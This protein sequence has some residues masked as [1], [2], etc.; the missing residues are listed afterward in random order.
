VLIPVVL[1]AGATVVGQAISPARGQSLLPTLADITDVSIP[2]GGVAEVYL[3]PGSP[4]LNAFHLVFERGGN[5]ESVG[6]VAVTATRHGAT[7]AQAIRL[8]TLST[9]HFVGYTTLS[10]GTWRFNVL[11]RIGGRTDSFSVS[12]VLG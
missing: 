8:A 2:G 1:F 10:T 6:P 3:E 12:R 9:G 11:V 4:G 5:P 7:G